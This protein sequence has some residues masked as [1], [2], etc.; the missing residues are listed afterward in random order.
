[1]QSDRPANILLVDDQTENLLVLEAVLTDPG[2]KIVRAHSGR[3]ALKCLLEQEFA[4]VVLDIQ[5]PDMNGFELAQSMRQ[6]E[7]TKHTPIIF[8]TALYTEDADA[9]VAYSL[10]AVDFITK[11]FVP[12][13]LK[14]KVQV[15]V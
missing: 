7:S 15:F 3:E 4:I 13:V 11:P 12:E 9:S 6:R 8:L 1:M 14:S 10:G 2:Y 5:M